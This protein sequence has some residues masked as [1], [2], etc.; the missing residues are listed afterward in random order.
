M[1]SLDL[2]TD[3]CTYVFMYDMKTEQVSDPGKEREVC[4]L[5]RK[6]STMR[7]LQSYMILKM[8]L[9]GMEMGSAVKITRH[10]RGPGFDSLHPHGDSQLSVTLVLEDLMSSS[11]TEGP[12]ICNWDI[13]TCEQNSHTHNE[14]NPF[15]LKGSSGQEYINSKFWQFIISFKILTQK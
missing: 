10:Y 11:D 6:Y 15:F 4:R 13:H 2:T 14:I 1:Q 12:Q 5:Q 7:S 3:I 8:H 9:L